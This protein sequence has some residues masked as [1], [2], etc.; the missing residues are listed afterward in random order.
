MYSQYP[1]L[2][3]WLTGAGHSCTAFTARL[4]KFHLVALP[5]G[6]RKDWSI[7]H[8]LQG[9]Y[10]FVHLILDDTSNAFNDIVLDG[11]RQSTEYSG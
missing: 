5:P 1:V 11:T 3:V 9:H 2:V 7:Y 6:T 4:L 8:A 10:I